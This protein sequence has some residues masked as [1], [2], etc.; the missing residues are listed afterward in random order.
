MMATA[1]QLRFRKVT[2]EFENGA[3]LECNLAAI[4]SVQITTDIMGF[5]D[6]AEL[7]ISFLVSLAEWPQLFEPDALMSPN[8]LALPDPGTIEGANDG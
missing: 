7:D 3:I 4:R 6:F 5:D 2:F 8:N 1:R